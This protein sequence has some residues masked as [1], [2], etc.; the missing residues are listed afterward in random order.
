L[1]TEFI[2][3]ATR[4]QIRL[5]PDMFQLR[6]DRPHAWLQRLCIRILRKLGCYALTNIEVQTKRI[7]RDI[8]PIIEYLSRQKFSVLRVLDRFEEDLPLHLLIGSEE[9]HKVC[10]QTELDPQYF[11]YAGE[12]SVCG[13]RYGRGQLI[14]MTVHVIP[15]M[16]GALVVPRLD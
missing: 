12:L 6:E 3:I 16:T 13:G 14:G 10:R 15:W 9:W 2:R 8:D 7:D 5:S 1:K 4:T 11:S